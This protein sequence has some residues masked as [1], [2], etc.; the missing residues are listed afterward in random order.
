[1]PIPSNA[2]IIVSSFDTLFMSAKRPR[3]VPSTPKQVPVNVQMSKIN[4]AEAKR[5]RRAE[6]NRRVNNG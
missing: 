5:A 4:R 3:P 1:M 6:R 2:E